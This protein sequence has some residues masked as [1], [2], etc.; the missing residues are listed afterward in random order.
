MVTRWFKKLMRFIGNVM[1]FLAL[2]L[3][4]A[5]FYIAALLPGVDYLENTNPV[6]TSFMRTDRYFEQ[7]G[8]SPQ[9]IRFVPLA[10]LPPS[11]IRA[12]LVTEDDYF[13]SHQ[14]FNWQALQKAIEYD[15]KKGRLRR[16]GSTLTQ[17][18]ARNLF[19]TRD[20]TMLRKL[21]EWIL[22]SRLEE[23][24][25]KSRILELYLNVVEFGPG[26]YG[27]AQASEYHFKTA[28]E[29]LSLSQA[30]LLAAFLPSPKRYGKKPYPAFAWVRQKK[31]LAKMAS[32]NLTVPEGV[33]TSKSVA[34]Q[35][36]LPTA[37]ATRTTKQDHPLPDQP[38]TIKLPPTTPMPSPAMAPPTVAADES[39][40]DVPTEPDDPPFLDE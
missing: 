39:T 23:A 2:F 21:R 32:Y 26:I 18:L 24:L 11:L 33:L 12:V 19:L 6:I 1:L 29:N 13:F 14:G 37:T 25:S 20:K 36:S 31:I 22:T 27:V 35:K 17:Q 5:W 7:E 28:P 38:A 4:I 15:K 9:V 3:I 34:K 30:A 8:V 16:G 10:A 40:L